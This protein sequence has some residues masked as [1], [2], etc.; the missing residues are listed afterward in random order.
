MN[1]PRLFT[2]PRLGLALG[3]FATVTMVTSIVANPKTPPPPLNG[4]A[5]YIGEAVC[6]ACHQTQNR[7]LDRPNAIKDSKRTTPTE[8]RTR[9][10]LAF[11]GRRAIAS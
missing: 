10:A 5:T 6:I 7:S 4:G 3:A 8:T 1:T 2:F 9:S 11:G